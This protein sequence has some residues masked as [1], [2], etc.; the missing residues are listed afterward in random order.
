MGK[1]NGRIL[2]PDSFNRAYPV[3]SV[4]VYDRVAVVGRRKMMDK[5][6]DVD[7]SHEPQREQVSEFSKRSRVRMLATLAMGRDEMKSLI[8]LTYGVNYPIDGRVAKGN[9]NSLLSRFRYKFGK[10]P[11]FWFME[12]QRR[13]APHYH[14]LTDV[15][16]FPERRKWL[17]LRWANVIHRNENWT[18]SRLDDRQTYLTHTSVRSFH[19]HEK[20]W[21]EIR[22]RDGAIRYL[23]K[24]AYKPK[25][26]EVPERYRNCGRF[27]GCSRGFCKDA[28]DASFETDELELRQMLKAKGIDTSEWDILPKYCFT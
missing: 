28:P 24:Y 9:L 26:K 8:T 18:Y 13:G 21:E 2:D 16:P 5:V 4:D 12:F 11:Y 10:R 17:G 3:V 6:K 27:W 14:I 15:L 25:Q 20:A 22:A 1:T 7:M 19:S 23:S